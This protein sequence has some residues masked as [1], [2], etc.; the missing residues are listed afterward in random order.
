MVA[1]RGNLV[2]RMAGEYADGVMIAT[3][4]TPIGVDARAGAGRQGAGPARAA[5]APTSALT[6]GSM[7]GSHRDP[8]VAQAALRPMI[9]GFLTTS[10]PDKNFV[11]VVGQEVSPELEAVLA[12]KDRD[13]SWANAHL[14]SDELL[15]QFCWAGTPEQVAEQIAA[16]VRLGITDVTVVLHPPHDAAPAD[17][18]EVIRSFAEDVRPMVE[19]ARSTGGRMG[20]NGP[21][22]P[23][24]LNRERA[25]QVLQAERLDGLLATTVENVYYLSNFWCENLLLLPYQTQCYAVVSGDDLDRPIVALGIN[26]IANGLRACPPQT[27][28]CRSAASTAS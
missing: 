9:A 1:T 10:Y 7:P 2:L 12:K 19:A 24:L 14:V 23:T 20:F 6:R 4:A 3:Y 15:A 5:R 17:V 13:H 22:D 18:E 25:R 28:T 21:D 11:H 26:E 16:V 27:S 8:R